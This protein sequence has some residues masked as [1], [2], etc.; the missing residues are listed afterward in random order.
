V[1]NQATL[2]PVAIRAGRILSERV[3]GGR[4]GLKM[5]YA[6]IATVIFS[7]PVIGTVGL[8][9]EAAKKQHGEENVA[10][11]K[12]NFVNMFFSPMEKQEDK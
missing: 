10:V 6:N 11:Y 4:T 2:T 3:F 9:E 12:S 8:S 7:H 1:T 5:S